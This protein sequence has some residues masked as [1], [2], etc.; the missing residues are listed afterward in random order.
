MM[1]DLIVS[2]TEHIFQF[3]YFIETIKRKA[4]TCKSFE[5]IRNIPWV[6]QD[7]KSKK[8]FV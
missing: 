2:E 4:G 1:F 7:F 5:N 8:A 3:K 6:S